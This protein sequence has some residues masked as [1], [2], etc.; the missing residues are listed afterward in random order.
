MHWADAKTDAENRNGYLATITS[1]AEWD[2]IIRQ[3]GKDEVTRDP[4]WFGLYQTSGNVE[5][6]GSWEWITSESSAY[7]NWKLGEPDNNGVNQA[8][9]SADALAWNQPRSIGCVVSGHMGDEVMANANGLVTGY[10]IEFT[11]SS[12]ATKYHAV[13]SAAMSWD[14]ARVAAYAASSS[15]GVLPAGSSNSHLAT[16]KTWTEFNAAKIQIEA[17][18]VAANEMLWLGGYQAL[19]VGV[20]E[21]RR[22][23]NQSWYWI[24]DTTP[25]NGQVNPSL[26]DKLVWTSNTGIYSH[27]GQPDNLS[28]VVAAQDEN[29]GYISGD[30]GQWADSID[31]PI[32]KG[33]KGYLMEQENDLTKIPLASLQRS[34]EW[35]SHYR[36]L[37]GAEAIQIGFALES[38]RGASIHLGAAAGRISDLD[39]AEET[40]SFTH[41]KILSESGAQMLTV[42]RDAMDMILTLINQAPSLGGVRK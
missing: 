11:D 35:V 41:A 7:Q 20:V 18:G 34:L 38:V 37:C 27:G 15:T 5:P 30:S 9:Q 12:N 6:N 1:P 24:S 17:Q 13:R 2:E 23:S 31:D 19:P 42:A 33:V 16:L 22:T 26:D 21:T 10:V 14:A 28:A 3:L 40:V 29:V 39:I 25:G 36:A 32:P 8:S 4:L